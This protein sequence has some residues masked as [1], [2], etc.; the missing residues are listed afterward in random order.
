MQLAWEMVQDKP[1]LGVGINN[2]GTVMQ[3]YLR[4]ETRGE[5]LYVV[6]NKYLALMAEQGAVGLL[7][8]GLMYGYLLWL[9]LKCFRTN[10]TDIAPLALGIGCAL[11]V[12]FA[13]MVA[14][15]F[16][17]R[18]VIQAFWTFAAIIVAADQLLRSE[19]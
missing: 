17:S 10:D 3:T 19:S 8:F 16:N 13:H 12:M 1:L 11:L 15:V 14:D 2:F 18:S 7:T 4:P 9:C 6:H 5:W